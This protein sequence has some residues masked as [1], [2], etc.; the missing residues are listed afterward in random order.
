MFS[1]SEISNMKNRGYYSYTLKFSFCYK[2]Q[3]NNL[4]YHYKLLYTIRNLSSGKK[5]IIKIFLNLINVF[6][7]FNKN[8]LKL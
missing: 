8:N 2:R 6:D 4:D 7:L 5:V 1:N 3:K